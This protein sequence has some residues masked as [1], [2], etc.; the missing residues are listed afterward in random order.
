MSWCHRFLSV[1]MV[2]VWLG[3][4]AWAKEKVEPKQ[5]NNPLGGPETAAKETREQPVEMLS[6]DASLASRVYQQQQILPGQKGATA[7]TTKKNKNKR[8]AKDKA[9]IDSQGLSRGSPES[10]G[11]VPILKTPAANLGPRSFI[12]TTKAA[13]ANERVESKNKLTDDEADSKTQTTLGS[14]SFM[15]KTKALTT[16]DKEE[17]KIKP[18]GSGNNPKTQPGSKRSY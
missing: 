5:L 8:K 16:E 15:E 7:G 10:G 14:R 11:A 6:K 12:D 18:T 17:A 9:E 4:V 13:M 3:S 1:I 2:V